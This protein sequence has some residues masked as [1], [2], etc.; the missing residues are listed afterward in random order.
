VT[1]PA[2]H[3]HDRNDLRRWD[4][5]AFV[6]APRQQ[7]YEYFA[8]PANR[9]A[10]QASLRRVEVLDEGPPRVGTRWVDH[11]VGAPPFHLRITAMRLGELWAEVGTSGP[12][13]AWGTLLFEDAERDGV[14][15]TVVRCIARVRG[16]GPARVL[17]PFAMLVAGVLVRND[18]AR[19][20]R[21][22]GTPTP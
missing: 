18:L 11:V 4:A 21:V 19:A 6:A 22:L 9:P 20:A 13:T 10:W 1:P 7:V 3:V 17:A 8:D 15:G 12:F 5:A 16:R 14:H 2:E